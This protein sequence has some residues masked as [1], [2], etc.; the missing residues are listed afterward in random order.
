MDPTSAAPSPSPGGPSFIGPVSF[1][2]SYYGTP[3]A[4]TLAHAAKRG[5]AAAIRQMAGE[6]AALVPAGAVLVPMPG[7]TGR[8]TVAWRLARAL[9]A[10]TGN[11][12]ADVLRG[13]SRPSLYDL[14]LEGRPITPDLLGLRLEGRLPPG[15]PVLLDNVFDTGTTAL[16]A[17]RLI[18]TA[19]VLVYAVVDTGRAASLPL[20]PHPCSTLPD[21]A[22]GSSPARRAVA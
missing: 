21:L 6:L 4:R 8:A 16:A 10:M 7:R 19:T 3:G 9:C 13:P 17:L 18:P 12:V 15:V 1:A 14:K 5:V 22:D 20:P 11:P 2:A